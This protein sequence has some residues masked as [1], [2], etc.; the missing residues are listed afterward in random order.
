MIKN[1][2]YEIIKEVIKM[3]KKLKAKAM[4]MVQFVK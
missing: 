4:G 1:T 2:L 3:R